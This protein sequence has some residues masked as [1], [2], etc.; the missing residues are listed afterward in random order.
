MHYHQVTVTSPPKYLETIGAE[1]MRL[2]SLGLV[3]SDQGLIAYFPGDRPPIQLKGALDI[4]K[5]LIELADR[6]VRIGISMGSL[7]GKDWN[8]SW[9]KSFVPLPVGER[10]IILPPWET[11]P[12]GRSPLVIDPGMAFGTGHHETTRSCIILIERFSVQVSRERFLDLGTGTGLLAIAAL[13][14]GFR[15]VE[16]VDTDPLA[17]EAA[18]MNVMLNHASAIRLATGG[19]DAATGTFDM[20]AANLI[21]DTLVALADGIARRTRPDGIAVLS[22]ILREQ[23]DEVIDA[24]AAAGMDCR[25]RLRDGKWVSL[26]CRR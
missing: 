24:M 16:G 14:L 26:A 25:E 6:H 1:L 15:Q 10:F 19:L 7:E 22:G 20:L 5:D 18:R 13:H 9:K 11:P 4:M 17:I 12:P 8:V 3:E 2:G 21:S 23:E